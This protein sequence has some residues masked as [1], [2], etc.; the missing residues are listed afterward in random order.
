[1]LLSFIYF[2][3][4][5][6]YTDYIG[7]GHTANITISS[8]S[9]N[10]ESPAENLLNG[11]G[12][13]NKYFEASRFLSQATMGYEKYHVDSLL[14]LQFESWI[15]SQFT[16]NTTLLLP[17]LEE[18]WDEEVAVRTANG[19]TEIYGPFS[20]H[21]S[22]AWWDV[23]MENEDLLRHRVA[24]ALSQ[25]FVI[26]RFSEL[27]DYG[28][29]MASF[30]DV[31]L[32]NAF[33]NYQDLLI[34]VS[35]HPCMGYYLSHLNNPKE[36]L[37]ENIHPDENYAREIMQLFTIGLNQLNMDG[38]EI[39]DSDGNPI[40]TY[41]NN[42]IKELAKVF[43]GLGAGD[44]EDYVDWTDSPFFGLEFWGTKKTTPMIM[45][46]DYHDTNAK[47]LINNFAIP[48]G[49][50]GMTDITMAIENLMNHPNIAPFVSY[51]LIQRLVTSNPTIEYVQRVSDVFTDNGS[52]V[53]GDMKAV[54]KAILLDE[55]ARSTLAM[56]DPFNGKLQEPFLR[57][58]QFARWIPKISNENRYWNIGFQFYDET[59]QHVLS[60]PT[61]FNFYTYDYQPIG[62]IS[63]NGLVAP[64]FKLHNTATSVG[65]INSTYYWLFWNS[66]MYSWI[67]NDYLN[68]DVS[69][70]TADLESIS[71]HE[72]I[73]INELDRHLTH[74]QMT[75]VT[76]GIL[77]N[78]LAQLK[79]D[80][81]DEWKYYRARIAL[82]L[83]LNSP[84]YNI[85]K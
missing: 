28:R 65:Y 79:W 41:D 3:G 5:T 59:K 40:P 31:L 13:D 42:D 70:N 64:E 53:K 34:D 77:R 22:Y 29:G 35:L 12:L 50:D 20:A 19:E 9:N 69:L 54:I 48:A 6:Q 73:L 47:T 49:Q 60:S 38:T 76:R 82:Y 46:Q 55:E 45:Y 37:E 10:P 21:F 33:G 15:D 44:I 24:Y 18:I 7:A 85:S 43:T 51:R 67:P 61:V 56:E 26:S 72:E 27:T 1:M 83:T 2:K 74:G 75:E 14:D 81:N 62:E 52:G 30:Y 11:E 80:W 58:S 17:R 36:N 66:L 39:L 32:E 4:F 68:T 71:E 23:N 78:A 8:S 57:Y 84:D 63:D 16:K 25:I